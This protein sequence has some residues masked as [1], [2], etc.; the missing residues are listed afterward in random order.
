MR[1]P[2]NF[3][4]ESTSHAANGL[5]DPL[6]RWGEAQAPTALDASCRDCRP[7]P[8]SGLGLGSGG[9]RLRTSRLAGRHEQRS[10]HDPRER[11][12]E[13]CGN[14][15]ASNAFVT[16][17]RGPEAKDEPIESQGSAAGPQQNV[18]RTLV[19]EARGPAGNRNEE[20]CRRHLGC[21]QK[22]AR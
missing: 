10:C 19:L 14:H 7:A 8:R 22:R 6:V 4:A 3:V 21:V 2:P 16:V 13:Q 15:G 12:Q 11:P 9:V 18:T 5:L 20:E 17:E 1:R